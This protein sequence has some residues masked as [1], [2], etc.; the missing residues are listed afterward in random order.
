MVVAR[1]PIVM[2]V[3]VVTA[4]GCQSVR[5]APTATQDISVVRRQ[6][7]AEVVGSFESKRTF[8][9]MEAARSRLQVGD[10]SGAA[11]AAQAVLRR[12]P[13]NAE[14]QALLLELKAASGPDDDAA[15]VAQT[16]L[17]DAALDTAEPFALTPIRMATHAEADGQVGRADLSED[18]G[19]QQWL[20][21]ASA[22]LEVG[23]VPTAR[24]C[25]QQ[26]LTAEPENRQLAVAASVLTL[27]YN[28]PDLALDLAQSALSRF[29]DDAPL[30]RVIGLAHYRRGDFESSQLALQQALSLDNGHPLTYFLLGHTLQ[31]LGDTAAAEQYFVQSRR[32]NPADAAP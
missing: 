32:A 13:E 8:A 3:M 21:E 5:P 12:D 28:Q 11:D 20:G 23:D 1:H 29:D 4:C 31:K 10:V 2:L 6:R 25:M 18:K 27:R 26:A 15:A 19:G 30:L 24:H 14:A 22:A 17:E 9:Q 7:K 16:S